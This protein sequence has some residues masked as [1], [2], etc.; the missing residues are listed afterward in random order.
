MNFEWS[1]T[2]PLL[3]VRLFHLREITRSLRLFEVNI[4]FKIVLK[5]Q[6]QKYLV[7]FYYSVHSKEKDQISY[8]ESCK[9]YTTDRR[10]FG[11]SNVMGPYPLIESQFIGSVSISYRGGYRLKDQQTAAES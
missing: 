6:K 11:W 10:I 1:Y 8:W 3:L 5:E 2:G 9:N 7:Q 4:G